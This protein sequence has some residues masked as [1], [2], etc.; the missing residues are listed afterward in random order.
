MFDLNG[1]NTK[2]GQETEFETNLKAAI[3]GLSQQSQFYEALADAAYDAEEIDP[4]MIIERYKRSALINGNDRSLQR[5][6]D[7]ERLIRSQKVPLLLQPYKKGLLEN[8]KQFLR[9]F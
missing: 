6:R 4:E 7:T 8:V 1:S 9:L 3:L 2:E 5:L